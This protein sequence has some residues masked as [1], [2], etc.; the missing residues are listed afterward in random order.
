MKTKAL[1]LTTVLGLA[2][3]AASANNINL[4][5][6]WSQTPYGSVGALSDHTTGGVV[7]DDFQCMGPEKIYAVRW[8]GSYGTVTH[9]PGPFDISFHYSTGPHP[10]S[11]PAGPPIELYQ[12]T[13]QEQLVD[14]TY[15]IYRYDAYL[16]VPFDQWTHSQKTQIGSDEQVTIL[17]PG[18]LFIDICKPSN[19]LWFWRGV[20]PPHPRLAYAIFGSGHEGPWT[21]STSIDMA[22]ELMTIP[23][24]GTMSLLGL[25]GLGALIRRRRQR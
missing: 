1:I 20:V 22:F 18:E 5:P 7:A 21:T 6:K 13:P 10:D 2:G 3:G 15:S 8:W 11:V 23:E 9:Q 12:V 17:N 4:L 19:E 16:P 24:P 14:A 25:G